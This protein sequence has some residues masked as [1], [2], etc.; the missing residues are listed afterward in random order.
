MSADLTVAVL[1][2]HRPEYLRAMLGSVV[3]ACPPDTIVE[4]RDHSDDD[5][6]QQVTEEVA[7]GCR[8]GPVVRHR[9]TSPRGQLANVS[10]AIAECETTFLCI[11][12]D[13]DLVEPPLFDELLP[14]IAADPTSTFATGAAAYMDSEGRALP[15]MS[16][17]PF[18]KGYISLQSMHE[19]ARFHV[20]ERQLRPAMGTI[21]R[22]DALRTLILPAQAPTL[23]D[24]W[25]G[26]HM[27]DTGLRGYTSDAVVFRY[28][29]HAE[30]VSGAANDLPG[31]R[32]SIEQFLGD[33]AFA[34]VLPELRSSLHEFERSVLI[35]H[36][37]TSDRS[38][39]MV[40]AIVEAS[41]STS[42]ARRT[43]LRLALTRP[44]SNLTVAYLRWANPRL[45]SPRPRSG[46][47]RGKAGS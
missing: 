4:V 28:R 34:S 20:V 38:S 13:D 2:R 8:A 10:G 39:K 43:A 40:S 15:R 3:A 30:S 1:S 21:F 35:G 19:R 23:P 9:H 32:W 29:V 11:L 16:P 5:R 36:Y 12:H 41:A 27:M 18:T 26:R 42:V 7:A 47:S 14:A 25:I 24:L 6:C 31:Y 44:F 45:R 46:T 22:I 33:P 17:K 37:V